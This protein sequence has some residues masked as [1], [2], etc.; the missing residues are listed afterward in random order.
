MKL[1]ISISSYLLKDTFWRWREQP[2]TILTRFVVVYALVLPSLG[3]LGAFALMAGSLETRLRRNGIDM[4]YVSEQV[5]SRSD[6]RASFQRQPRYAPLARYGSM[7]QLLQLFGLAKSYESDTARIVA[8]PDASIPY[9]GG[10]ITPE[11]PVVFLSDALPTGMPIHTEIDNHFFEARVQRPSGML[12]KF[13]QENVVLVP[14]GMLPRLEM[15][16]HIRISI[17]KTDNLSALRGLEQAVRMTAKLDKRNVF[18]RSSLKLLDDLERLKLLQIQWRLGLA[19]AAGGVL[20]LVLGTLTVLEYRQRAFVIALLRSFGV[21]RW[22]VFG[23]QL[24]E[25]AVVVNMAGAAAYFTLAYTQRALYRAFG[26]G[27]LAGFSF[28]RMFVEVLVIFTCINI[29]VVISTWPAFHILRKEVG[30]ILS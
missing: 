4:M 8:Y 23:A 18:V 20:A 5:Y 22:M 19:I 12:S 14:E 2:G 13:F 27:A 26:A 17:L 30:V 11:S 28:E 16:G 15:K 25:S 1:L 21:R 6:D 24:L 3:L 29:G 10:I 7:F 9:L